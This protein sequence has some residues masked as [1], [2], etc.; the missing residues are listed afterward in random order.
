VPTLL[1]PVSRAKRASTL[2]NALLHVQLV[3]LGHT[4]TS[5]EALS[6]LHAPLVDFLQA[7]VPTLLQLVSCAKRASTHRREGL[8]HALLAV[9][10]GSRTFTVPT[11]RRLVFS[12]VQARIRLL[13]GLLHVQ[14]ALP[15]DFP[16]WSVPHQA[17]LADPVS[18]GGIRQVLGLFLVLSVGWVDTRPYLMPGVHQ[19][20]K[21]VNLAKPRVPQEQPRARIVVLAATCPQVDSL[22]AHTAKEGSI[23][24]KW[25]RNRQRSVKSA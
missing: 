10:E 21:P 5:P 4:A 7:W 2:W 24:L 1:Q 23:P 16:L 15:E 13:E 17:R 22:T 20:A 6:V 3:R 12:A 14:L 9:Q 25:E 18:L 19:L 11:H 8:L